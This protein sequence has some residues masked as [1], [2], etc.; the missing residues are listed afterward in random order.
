L[1]QR[2]PAGNGEIFRRAVRFAVCINGLETSPGKAFRRFGTA[3][4][5]VEQLRQGAG[6][7]AGQAGRLGPQRGRSASQ[8][9]KE[10][11]Q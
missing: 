2:A 11:W 10:T 1:R 9:G 3:P 8:T 5:G 4:L 7:G 6:T